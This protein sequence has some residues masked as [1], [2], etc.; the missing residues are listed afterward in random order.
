MTDPG[1]TGPRLHG[2]RFP[3][4]SQ[5]PEDVMSAEIRK[6]R[7]IVELL[8]RCRAVSGPTRSRAL[9]EARRQP[10]PWIGG[11]IGWPYIE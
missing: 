7:Q 10:I 1:Q 5:R 8:R 9:V 6:R 11:G 3:L 2:P 4:A